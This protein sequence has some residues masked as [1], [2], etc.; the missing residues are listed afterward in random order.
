VTLHVHHRIFSL[1]TS[2]NQG[3]QQEQHDSIAASLQRFPSATIL[4][5]SR[6]AWKSQLIQEIC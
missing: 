4:L 2:L 1:I 6:L 5:Q 3:L